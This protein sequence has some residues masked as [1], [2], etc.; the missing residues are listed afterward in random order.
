VSAWNGKTGKRSD[1]NL[2]NNS[3]AVLKR[4]LSKG[5]QNTSPYNL[6]NPIII[7]LILYYRTDVGTLIPPKPIQ[8]QKQSKIKYH[9][10]VYTK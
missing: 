2:L 7:N 10:K 3:G 1:R 4:S 8:N 6:E 9:Q 5:K